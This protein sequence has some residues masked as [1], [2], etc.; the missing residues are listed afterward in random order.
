V[1]HLLAE[2]DVALDGEFVHMPPRTVLPRPVQTPHPP[3]WVGGVGPGNAERAAKR[4]LGMLFFAQSTAPKE[5][6]STIRAYRENIA[7]AKPLVPGGVNDQTAGFV[8]G[9]VTRD[10]SQ[11]ERVRKLAPESTVEHTRHGSTWMTK[12]WPDP[13]WLPDAYARIGGEQVAGLL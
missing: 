6:A 11:R 12:G 4:G 7:A 1:A 2:E 8:N 9:L 3:L 13:K 5:L 10:P